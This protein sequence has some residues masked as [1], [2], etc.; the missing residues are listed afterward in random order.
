MTNGKPLIKICGIRTVADALAAA[1]AG[2]D[3]V[4]LVRAPGSKRELDLKV[5]TEISQ[6]VPIP[7]EPIGVYV[8]A[9]ISD[10][11]SLPTR[12]IQLHGEE[13]PEE[14]T[15]IANTT[16][17]RV[18]RGFPFDPN[19]CKAWDAHPQIDIL[20][21][22]GPNAGS[23]QGFDHDL[24]AEVISTLKTPVIVAGGLTPENVGEIVRTVRPFGVDVSSGVESSPGTKDHG[25]IKAFCEAVRDAAK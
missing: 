7:L 23:G 6:Q 3:A 18:I 21:L 2:A 19:A 16:H 24:L 1:E 14:V 5:A 13:T 20:L 15:R 22:D 9:S 25:L 4:G 11:E 8:E 10:I 12:W 17:R